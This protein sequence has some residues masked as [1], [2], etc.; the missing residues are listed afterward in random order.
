M[1]EPPKNAPEVL[2]LQWLGDEAPYQGAE[3]VT[4]EAVTWSA[5]RIN[6]SDLR[7][8]HESALLPRPI[9]EAPEE[10]KD[11]R[12]LLLY[13]GW[14]PGNY[15]EGY[16]DS[17]FGEWCTTALGVVHRPPTH[18]FE[19]PCVPSPKVEEEDSHE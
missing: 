19:I 7:Y 8:V 4:S 9:E 5:D 12:L 10:I 1:I 18:Y 14:S 3:F 13:W 16:W 15:A 11:G 17:G 6:D 2:F